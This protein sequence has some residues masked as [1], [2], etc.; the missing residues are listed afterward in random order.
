MK[1]QKETGYSKSRKKRRKKGEEKL[2]KEIKN[3]TGANWNEKEDGYTQ[4]FLE[5]NQQNFWRPEEIALTSDLK[6]WSTLSDEVKLAYSKNLAVLTFLD[7][8][9]GD[10]GM[11]VVG[12]SLSNEQHQR[13][14][15]LSFM[16]AVENSIHAKSYSNIFMTYLP[17]IEIDELFR[18]CE[19][20]QPMQQILNRI[21]GK[22]RDLEQ[23]LAEKE[24]TNKD[25]KDVDFKVAQYKAMVASVF[26][27]SALFYTGFYYPLWFAGQGKLKQAGEIISLIIRDEG[28]HGLYV[29]MLADEILQSLDSDIQEELKQWVINFLIELYE[30]ELDLIEDIYSEVGL[31]HD[32]RVFLRYN[33]NKALMN[34]NLPTHFIEEEVNPVVLRGIDVGNKQIDYFSQKGDSYSKR[35]VE[36]LLNEDFEFEDER[37]C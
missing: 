25:I 3:F 2:N 33:F 32:V 29:G 21:V 34:L 8:W 19:N 24:Y 26:L 35:K 30:L 11:N 28:V 22:Y 4:V 15:L 14:A 23:L 5:M 16:Q 7:T 18:W 37:I 1:V 9:Q 12:R 10:M 31:T 13:K 27:E 6:V 36:E 20:N 17:T